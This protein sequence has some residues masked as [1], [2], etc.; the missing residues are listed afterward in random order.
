MNQ[1]PIK[2]KGGNNLYQFAFNTQI[3][4]ELFGLNVT[5]AVLTGLGT[6]AAVLEPTDTTPQKKGGWGVALTL[7]VVSDAGIWVY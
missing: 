6:D 1:D 3:W 4:I 5:G 2:L 7:A